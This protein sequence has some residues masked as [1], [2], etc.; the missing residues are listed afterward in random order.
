MCHTNGNLSAILR[1]INEI[2]QILAVLHENDLALCD[3]LDAIATKMNEPSKCCKNVNS[4]NK[5][6]IKPDH[7][8]SDKPKNNH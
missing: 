5:P 8:P 6:E 2:K 3:R 1:G 7:N 4:S